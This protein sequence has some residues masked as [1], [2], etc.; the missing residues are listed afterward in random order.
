VE[1]MF[2]VGPQL[3]EC[4]RRLQQPPGLSSRLIHVLAN[5]RPQARLVFGAEQHLHVCR[6]A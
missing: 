4:D 6:W 2:G 1:F 3:G 5:D